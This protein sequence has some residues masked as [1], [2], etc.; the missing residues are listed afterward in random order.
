MDIYEA[1]YARRTVRD[2]QEKKITPGII[3]KIIDAGLQAPTNNHLREWEF[4]IITDQ[5]AR[6]K[7]VDKVNKNTTDKEAIKIIDKWGV[8]DGCQREMYIESIPKQ[9]RMLLN[10]GCIIIPCFRQNWPLLTP[11]NL[12]A[13]NPFASIWCCIEN[14]LLAAVSEGIYG[15][16]RIPFDNEI[17]HI[18]EI[19]KI[20]DD[21]EFP[22]Y[23]ALGYP[24]ENRKPVLQHSIK[25]EERLHFNRW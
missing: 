15:V 25:A 17:Q 8:T 2:F 21:Y 12:S 3:T 23:I 24:S 20:P 6:L 4:I 5:M 18:R 22:C 13:L 1:I 7:V 10:A 19:L 16:T 14:I 11:A 9:Y